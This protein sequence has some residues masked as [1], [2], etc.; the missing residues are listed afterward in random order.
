MERQPERRRPPALVPRRDVK[1]VGPLQ[2]AAGDRL[3]EVARGMRPGWRAAPL[4]GRRRFDDCG[5]GRGSALRALARPGE[6]GEERP[7]RDEGPDHRG[8]VP[9]IPVQT[10]DTE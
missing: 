8:M 5:R 10:A 3:V 4:G 7:E 1:D 2:A 6:Y 9:R